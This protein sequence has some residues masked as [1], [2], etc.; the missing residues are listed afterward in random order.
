MTFDGVALKILTVPQPI[1]VIAFDQSLCDASQVW[2]PPTE[3]V[4]ENFQNFTYFS[5]FYLIFLSILTQ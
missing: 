2:C 5:N 1:A 3:F 4:P